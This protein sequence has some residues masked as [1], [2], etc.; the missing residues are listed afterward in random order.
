MNDIY[1]VQ[2]PLLRVNYNQTW[3]SRCSNGYMAI[4][5]ELAPVTAHSS[6]PVNMPPP[7]GMLFDRD[8]RSIFHP[9]PIS[10]IN[11]CQWRFQYHPQSLHL[12]FSIN[13]AYFNYGLFLPNWSNQCY[14]WLWTWGCLKVSEATSSR[15]SLSSSN[16]IL[17]K[18]G[19]IWNNQLSLPPNLLRQFLRILSHLTIR[20]FR[21]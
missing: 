2:N 8:F 13:T 16:V 5:L 7:R 12:A 14:W 1:S 11:Q 3:R 20:E 18:C 15:V 6:W 21:D 19:S 9:P 10:Y 4:I 17:V